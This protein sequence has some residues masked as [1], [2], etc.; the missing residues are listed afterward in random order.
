[1]I[2]LHGRKLL[3][4]RLILLLLAGALASG[5]AGGTVRAKEAELKV[6]SFN[7]RYSFGGQDEQKPENN[8]TDAAHP[9]RERVLRVIRDYGPDILGVQEA[10][11]LQI[12]DLREALPKLGF[13]GVGRD[14]GVSA[15]E[16]VGIFYRSDRFARS[17]AGSFWLSNEPEKPG[18]TFYQAPDAVPRMAS[19]VRLQDRES[20]RELVVLNTHFDHVSAPARRKSAELIRARL[21]EIGGD[22]PVIVMGDFNVPEESGPLR[23]LLGAGDSTGRVLVD[24][25]RAVHRQRSGDESTFNHWSGTTTGS[26][27]DFI[28]HSAELSATAA[29]IVRTTYD[30]YFPSDH[31]PVTATLQIAAAPK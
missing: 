7:I 4:Y 13:Y 26:R 29:D 9:R 20:G 10:R 3:R 6:M 24:S 27:I 25:Y 31:Y 14:D 28:L 19:W 30:G 12:V 15:G 18:T 23:E 16:Y 11:D 17:D 21:A 2:Q 8:W 5:L 22:L 1:M